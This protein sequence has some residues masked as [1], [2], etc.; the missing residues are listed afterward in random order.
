MTYLIEMSQDVVGFQIDY[1]HPGKGKA[2]LLEENSKAGPMPFL[3]NGKYLSFQHIP[4]LWMQNIDTELCVS[5]N[6]FLSDF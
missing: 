4:Y 2:A 3:K 6:L 1:S 5:A